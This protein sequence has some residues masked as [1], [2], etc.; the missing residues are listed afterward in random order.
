MLSADIDKEHNVIALFSDAKTELGVSGVDAKD[1][2]NYSPKEVLY[3]VS[4]EF[5]DPSIAK[6][7]V[8]APYNP[9]ITKNKIGN[10][11]TETHLTNYKPSPLA[12]NL[13]DQSSADISDG[14]NTYFVCKDGFPFAIHLDARTDAS[15]MNINLKAEGKRIDKVYSS[16][17]EWATTRN[18]SIKWWNR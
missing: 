7:E 12:A 6:E 13:F 4:I 8:A 14:K 11:Y 16:F 5:K 15:I 17:A 3:T 1:M 18:P 9:F 2:P 10:K